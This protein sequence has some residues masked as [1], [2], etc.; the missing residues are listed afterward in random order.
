MP[1]KKTGLNKMSCMLMGFLLF[2]CTA[3]AQRTITGKVINKTNQQPV[4][5]ATVLVKGTVIA[6][7]TDSYGTFHISVPRNNN[8]LEITSVGFEN[9]QIPVEGKNDLGEIQL[10][11]STGGLN[12]VVVTGYTSQRKKDITGAVSI[13]N[14]SDMKQTIS[15][16]TEALLQG[17]ASGVTVNTTGAPGGASVVQIR[18]VTS[19]G[20][21]APLVLIDGVPGSMHDI[22]ANDI[23]SIQVLKDAGGAAIYGVRGSNGIIVIT[24]K[25]GTGPVKI[26]YDGFIGSQQP[27][28]KSWDLAS[29][30]QT[31]EA[32][33]AQYFNDGLTPSDPQYGNGP[34]PVVPYYITPTGA[35]QGA[36]NTD[37]ADYNLYTNHITMAAQNGNN[38]FNDI[39]KPAMIMDHNLSV[40]GGTGKS[41]YFMSFN[42]LDQQGTLIETSLQRY[43]VRINTNF[44]LADDHIHVG[45]NAY[46]LYKTNPGYLNAPGVNSTNSINAAYQLPNIVPI[47]DIMGNYAGGISQGLGN[48]SNPVAIQDRQANNVNQDYQVVGNVFAEADF[49]KHFTIRTSA[50]GTFDNYYYNG[51]VTTPYEN[52]ENNKAANLY[53]ETYGSNSS[54]IWTN[55]LNYN[56]KIDKHSFNII[57]GTEYIYNTGRGV[58]ATR[59]NYYITDSSNL[60]VSPN[61]WT[62]NFGQASTQ[63]NNS[64]IVGDNGIQTPYQQAIFSLFARLDYNFDQKYYLSATIRRDG[65]SVFDPSQRYGNFPSV[66]AGWMI[67]QESFMR[68]ISW[69]DQLKIRGSWG[70]L[71]SISNINPTNAYTLYG[72]QI[73]QSY[74]DINGTSH[75]PAAGLYVS[76]YGNPNTTWEQD[77]ITDVGFDATI[78]KNKID[79]SFDWYKKLISGLLFIPAAP[80]TN[81]GTLDPFLNSGNVQNTGIDL[82]LTYHGRIRSDLSFDITGTF[83][84]YKNTVVSLP[85]G[86]LYINQPTGAQTVTSRIQPGQPLGAF[87]GYQVIGLFQNYTDVQKSPTQQDAA[88]GRFKYADVNHDGKIDGNDRTFFGNPNPKFTAGLNISVNYKNF[89]LYTFF[90][91]QVGNDII[92]NVKSS[93]D[94]PQGFG[95]QISTNVAVNSARLIGSNGQPTN[96]ND[97]TAQVANPGTNVPLLEKSANFSNSGAFNSYTMESGSFLRC[98]NLTIGYTIVSSA[99]KRL[100]FDRFRVY[101]QA[102]NLFTVTNYSGLDPELNPGS[103]TVFGYDNG[104]YPNNQKSYN[105][106]VNITIH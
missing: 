73:N 47:Y 87:F 64:G 82:S 4:A 60:T 95:N 94:F 70:K 28:S 100:H 102:T 74:Y 86:T 51:F 33:W 18:G 13:V 39:F 62:L 56:N 76:Q 97:P 19:S 9:A 96:I 75:S 32:K 78:I 84:S 77:I 98:R 42:Y 27:L 1:K 52:A 25:R 61:L 104:V 31:G 103:N 40:S 17:Q 48:A 80:G 91:T 41:S 35:P 63:T 11:I 83:T 16:S 30:T 43:S 81:G 71:G 92:N 38:W 57:G 37:P 50:G 90:Y 21:S 55:T 45:E 36:P 93:T 22:N 68:N 67:S 12:E 14:V 2:S 99:L 72:Q 49:L 105:V 59:G 5:N 54:M 26:S 34:I 89:D 15:G 24:T 58:N 29:P 44:S 46:V 7:Q 10:A 88:P 69:M 6:T 20:N 101:V 106:G 79:F 65:S 3:F 85:P 53:T 66:S 8:V 23:Q